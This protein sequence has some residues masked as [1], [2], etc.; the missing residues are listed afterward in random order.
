MKDIKFYIDLA[1]EKHSIKSDR[2][3]S[4]Q[5]EL[6]PMAVQRWRKGF[7]LPSDDT[8][9]KLAEMCGISK[10]QA[11]LELSYWRSEGEAKSTYKMLL[12]K[13]SATAACAAMTLVLSTSPAHAADGASSNI[14]ESIVYIMLNKGCGLHRPN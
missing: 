3:L 1:I 14:T 9:V 11:L 13:L 7:S 5:L 6:S 12:K 4:A 8:M 10:E 2:K